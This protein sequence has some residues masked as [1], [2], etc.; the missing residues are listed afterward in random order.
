MQ[1]CEMEWKPSMSYKDVK[2]SKFNYVVH[3]SMYLHK[4]CVSNRPT[5]FIFT[6]SHFKRMV[7]NVLTITT[8]SNC[9]CS[10]ICIHKIWRKL[11]PLDIL[12][13]V[14]LII[15][16]VHSQT[17][18]TCLVITYIFWVIVVVWKVIGANEA[19]AIAALREEGS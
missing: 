19:I 6:F 8:K 15:L 10:K 1:E 9:W 2:G 3:I 14:K 16:F 11:P 13:F 7:I 5:H 17:L 4:W 18:L 12:H